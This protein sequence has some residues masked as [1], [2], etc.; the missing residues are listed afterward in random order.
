MQIE[1]VWHHTGV[2]IALHQLKNTKMEQIKLMFRKIALEDQV[3]RM[4][5]AQTQA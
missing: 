4:L 5:E 1:Q 3:E 2:A